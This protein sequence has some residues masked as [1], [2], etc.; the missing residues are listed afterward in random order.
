MDDCVFCRIIKKEIPCDCLYENDKI[1]VMLDIN[2]ANQ[3]HTLL[4][5]KTHCKDITETKNDEAAELMIKAKEFAPKIAKAV[6]ADGF[7]LI[8]N[9]RPAAGQMVMHTHLH[10]I[11]RFKDDGLKHWPKK[12]ISKEEM[13][14]IKDKIVSFLKE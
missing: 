9:T 10:I 6:N 3:G 4:I 1:F 5:P 8:M 11:P 2:P 12:D 14:K 13:V 7:N